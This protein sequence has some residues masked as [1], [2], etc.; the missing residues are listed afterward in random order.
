MAIANVIK[1]NKEISFKGLMLVR[2]SYADSDDDIQYAKS[3][4]PQELTETDNRIFFLAVDKDSVPLAY[5][6]LLVL[7]ADN[8]PELANGKDIAHI[9][10]LRVHHGQQ[11]KGIGQA[12]IQELENEAKRRGVR[13][14]TLG[15]DNWNVRAIKFYQSLGYKEFK[16]EPGR[17]DEEFVI[18]MV[19]SL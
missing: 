18:C 12:L 3:R 6:Q 16:Q 15:V 1:N 4:Y 2:E 5:V 17:T 19:K 11:G 9:H 10:D 8:D 14:L 13:S 7:N